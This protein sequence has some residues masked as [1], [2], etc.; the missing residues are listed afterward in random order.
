MSVQTGEERLL[1]G[2][3]IGFLLLRG[4]FLLYINSIV[5]TRMGPILGATT[6]N[7][8]SINQ[9]RGACDELEVRADPSDRNSGGG[10]V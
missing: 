3:T 1:F 7:E 4:F 5:T 9:F 10:G 8:L 2:G 6:E